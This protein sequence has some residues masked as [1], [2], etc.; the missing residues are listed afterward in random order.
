MNADQI[1][2]DSLDNP[3]ITPNLS[4]ILTDCFELNDKK[5]ISSGN[6]L[7]KKIRE[8][9]LGNFWQRVSYR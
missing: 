2:L 6:P 4:S 9:Y 5:L 8:L 1:D 7:M 3:N